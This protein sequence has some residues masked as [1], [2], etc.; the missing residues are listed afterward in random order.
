VLQVSSEGDFDAAFAKARELQAG[1]LLLSAGEPL[2]ASRNAELGALAARHAVPAIGAG[3]DFA[4]A[5]ALGSY[6]SSIGEA[7]R[8]AGGYTARVLKGDKASDLPVQQATKVELIINLKAA[9]ALGINV[10]ITL[11]GRADEVIE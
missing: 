1:G 3:R 7:Y 6:G 8:L 9:Q 2:F 10:P 11:S 4:A 5:G